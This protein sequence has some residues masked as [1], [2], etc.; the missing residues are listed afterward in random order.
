MVKAPFK[1]DID[2]LGQALECLRIRCRARIQSMEAAG[3][4]RLDPVSVVSGVQEEAPADLQVTERALRKAL[5][6]NIAQASTPPALLALAATFS[7]EPDEI[8]IL[9]LALAPALDGTFN[10]LYGRL[11]GLTYRHHLDVD[12]ALNV[13]ASDLTHRL[14]LRGL[15]GA[16]GRLLTHNLLRIGRGSTELGDDFLN[17]EIRLPDRLVSHLLGTS[18]ADATLSAFSRLIEPTETLDQVILPAV[19]K[20]R[21]VSLVSGHA[22]YLEALKDWG[23]A[24]AIPYGRA[25]TLLFSGPSGTGKTLTA[26]AVAHHLGQRLLLVDTGRLLNQGA[27]FESNIDNMLREARL[28]QAVLFFDECDG[29]FNAANRSRGTLSILLEALERFEGVVVLATNIPHV[30]DAALDRRILYRVEFQLPSPTM[31][32]AIWSV[33]LPPEMPLSDDVDVAFLGRRFEFAGGYIKNSVLL[34]AGRAAQR[35]NA[36]GEPRVTHADLVEA[37]YAQLRSRLSRFADRET[38]TLRLADLVVTDDVFEQ[39]NEVID[40]VAAQQV[41]FQEWGFDRKF[42]KGRGLSALFDGEPGTGKTLAAEIIAAELGMALFRVNVAN[43]VSKYIGETEKNLTR[44]FAEARS[45]QSVLLFDEADSLFSKRVEVKGSND[46]FANMEVNVLL[47]LIERYDGLVILT[48]NLKQSLDTAFER[49]LSFKVNFPFPEAS[50]RSAI[51]QQLIPETA[52][53]AGDLDFDMLGKHFELSGGS[54]KN[55]VL[56]AAYG[57]ASSGQAMAM[58]HFENA[59]KRECQAAGK[60]YRTILNRDDW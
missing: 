59:A 36:G 51:W 34:A 12:V 48:T 2:Y 35:M 33:H 9:L 21:I 46:R 14:E 11:K 16:K 22:T 57:A 50:T 27:A 5:D 55:A 43:V 4:I 19:D 39:V 13:L 56:R 28:Q 45:A 7:L 17:L 42:N 8:E 15:F 31:R 26:R 30:L 54:I 20:E 25:V 24:K 52:P 40:S 32:Q 44:V 3:L 6:T 10:V 41:V 49:R 23:L 38:A 60:L 53:V 37:A 1:N 47:Q 58:S 18:D 29:L